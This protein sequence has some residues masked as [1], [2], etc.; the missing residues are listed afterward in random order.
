MLRVFYITVL[1][2]SSSILQGTTRNIIPVLALSS[3]HYYIN[4]AKYA[5]FGTTE[6]RAVPKIKN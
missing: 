5:S 3:K 6:A 1:E 4:S 2:S